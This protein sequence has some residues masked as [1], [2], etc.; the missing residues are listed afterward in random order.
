MSIVVRGSSSG[1]ARLA[2][3]PVGGAIGGLVEGGGVVHQASH[4][5]ERSG[6]CLGGRGAEVL[7]SPWDRG[8]DGAKGRRRKERGRGGGQFS[9]FNGIR[10]GC[11][12]FF[13]DLGYKFG[14]STVGGRPRG[15]R[16]HPRRQ[17]RRWSSLALRKVWVQV[18]IVAF[19]LRRIQV[20]FPTV[21]LKQN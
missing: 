8:D 10:S 14:V 4:R 7:R 18:L 16:C 19:A 2:V 17:I 5:T 21:P 1:L 20:V 9:V 6:P 3:L 11:L 15:G 12:L 13:P